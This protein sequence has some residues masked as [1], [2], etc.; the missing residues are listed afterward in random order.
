MVSSLNNLYF[1]WNGDYQ[2]LK[3][4]VGKDL[5]LDGVW[6]QPRGDKK[7]FKSNN[8]SITWR[9]NKSLLHF[10]GLEANKI[11]KLLCCI[12]CQSFAESVAVNNSVNEVVVV[13]DSVNSCESDSGTLQGR[14]SKSNAISSDMEGPITGQAINTEAIRALSDS[15]VH[16]TEVL[17]SLQENMDKSRQ[18]VEKPP[19]CMQKG[20]VIVEERINNAENTIEDNKAC[21]SNYLNA[22]KSPIEKNNIINGQLS[23]HLHKF[24]TLNIRFLALFYARRAIASKALSVIFSIPK[25]TS[26][27]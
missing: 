12:I 20:I 1:V 7:V 17:A 11:T 6:E 26:T 21:E 5:N 13:N 24:K 4:F 16:I 9:K 23:N 27:L 25:A 2:S 22:S 8:I 19:N 14:V 15:L 18:N 3:C 10:E